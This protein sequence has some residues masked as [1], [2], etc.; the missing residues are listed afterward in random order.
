MRSLYR[1]P[2]PKLISKCILQSVLPVAMASS[3][4][5]QNASD[6]GTPAESKPRQTTASTYARYEIETV[7]LANG[8]FSRNVP[9]ASISGR[10][11]LWLY[12]QATAIRLATGFKVAR[13]VPCLSEFVTQKGLHHV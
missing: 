11:V 5:V 13:R 9:L 4:L 2:F 12:R 1:Q 3:A 7:N 10:Y 8:N 6:N